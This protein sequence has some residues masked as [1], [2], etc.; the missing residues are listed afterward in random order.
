MHT[1]HQ[2]HDLIGLS[3]TEQSIIKALSTPKNVQEISR[4]SKIS[5]T[6]VNY[7][8]TSLL[9]RDLIRIIRNG[10]QMKYI[11]ITNDEIVDLIQHTLDNF[12]K[13]NNRKGARIKTSIEDEFI[14]HVGAREIIPAFTN[15]ASNN[16]DERIKAIQHHRSFK[17]LLNKVSTTQLVAFNKSII[18]HRLII[19]GIL[20]EGA[21]RDYRE[22][23]RSNP[24]KYE[25]T[26]KSLEGR[27]ADYTSFPDKFFNH[28][29]E[30]WLFKNTTLLINWHDEVAIEITNTG[31]TAFLK[32]MFE[33]VKSSGQKID[34]N[35]A[36]RKISQEK[37]N[38]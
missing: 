29:A 4:E 1:I 3:D 15:I 12:Q 35:E 28:D 8:L 10:K 33:F 27:M 2:L 30:I 5:R 9:Q 24:H 31:M 16:K 22:E 17:E 38:V 18:K 7:C 23:I 34:H 36:M 21:Y 11:S 37:S 13:S 14:I 20:N 25:A 6:G 19:D 26:V 32:D